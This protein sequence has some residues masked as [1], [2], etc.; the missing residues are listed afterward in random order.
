MAIEEMIYVL[1]SLKIDNL[2]SLKHFSILCCINKIIL[3]LLIFDH[4]DLFHRTVVIF[5]VIVLRRSRYVVH[6][7][8]LVLLCP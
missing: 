2:S 1:R 3:L 7:S 5:M 8:L 6:L 4:F